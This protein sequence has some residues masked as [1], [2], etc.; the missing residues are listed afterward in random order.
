MKEIQDADTV[1]LCDFF[2][3]RISEAM[4][5]LDGPPY[6]GARY[7]VEST[8]GRTHLREVSS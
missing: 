7:P 6:A 8:M 1:D 5:D 2:S 3:F 4:M